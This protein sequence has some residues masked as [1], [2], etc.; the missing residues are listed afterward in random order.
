MHFWHD[1]IASAQGVFKRKESRVK[2]ETTV[3]KCCKVFLLVFIACFFVL[4]SSYWLNDAIDCVSIE[5]GI[6]AHSSELIDR[7][8]LFHSTYTNR[9]KPGTRGHDGESLNESEKMFHTYYQHVPLLLIFSALMFYLPKSFWKRME[10]NRIEVIKKQIEKS[11]PESETVVCNLLKK[12]KYRYY[13][14]RY[15]VCSLCTLLAAIIVICL[16][17]RFLQGQF[18]TYGLHIASVVEADPK[19]WKDP[20]RTI[21]PIRTQCDYPFKKIHHTKY[22]EQGSDIRAWQIQVMECS[23]LYNFYNEWIFQALWFSYAI[24]LLVAISIQIYNMLLMM[25]SWI[26]HQI[27]QSQM[28][29][30]DDH[31]LEYEYS[32]WI[33]NWKT[34][35]LE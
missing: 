16:T 21:F 33:F 27:L 17:D 1:L 24:F 6:M 34:K 22:E 35:Q 10:G 3:F 31:I 2:I 19:D 20:M 26:R 4:G 13:F 5:P 11:Q 28:T 30:S 29:D 32:G 23:L 8:C 25:S 12:R 7:Y 15:F 18:L 14:L 9:S